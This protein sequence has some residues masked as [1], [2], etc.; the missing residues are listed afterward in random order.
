ML[1]VKSVVILKT[2]QGILKCG[3]GIKMWMWL[4]VETESY[5]GFGK[6]WNEED[7]RN[8]V[9]QKKDARRVV[10]ITRNQK[11]QEV[12]EKVDLCVVM[13]VSCLELPN[14]GL[15]RRKILLGLVV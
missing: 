8:T 15:G 10:Y 6:S 11:S 12:V 1:Q 3:G 13:V 14:K 2:N 9:R 7:R 5:L 4:S